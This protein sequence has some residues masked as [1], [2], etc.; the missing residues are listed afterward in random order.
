MEL[1]EYF[2]DKRPEPYIVQ[3]TIDRRISPHNPHNIGLM[4]IYELYAL[5]DEDIR[6]IGES[7]CLA[8]RVTLLF[9]IHM[10]LTRGFF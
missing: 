5:T 10:F 7:V 3:L 6:I 9:D 8:F 1:V 4:V 2:R